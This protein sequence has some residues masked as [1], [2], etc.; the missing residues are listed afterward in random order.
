MKRLFYSIFFTIILFFIPI[1]VSASAI[2]VE[3]HDT[4]YKP[5][6]IFIFEAKVDSVS[7]NTQPFLLYCHACFGQGNVPSRGDHV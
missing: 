5:G 2:A 7:K 4:I 1:E 3:V 6:N